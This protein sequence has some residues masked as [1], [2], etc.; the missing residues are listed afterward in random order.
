[1]TR[2]SYF[3][4]LGIMFTGCTINEPVLPKWDTSWQVHLKGDVIKISELLESNSSVSDSLDEATGEQ[5]YFINISDTSEPRQVSPQDLSTKTAD[6]SFVNKLGVFE[7]AQPQPKVSQGSTFSEIFADYNPQVGTPFPV[8]EP[9]VLTPDPRET[10][11]DEF[12][13]L[14]IESA[15]ISVVFHNDLILGIDSG[16]KIILK[17]LTRLNE[18]DSGLI[19]TIKFTAPIPPNTFLESNTISL[20]GKTISNQLQLTYRIPLS[21]TDS[22]IILTEDDLNSNFFTEVIMSPVKVNRA[23]AKIPG[24]SIIRVNTAPV[25]TDDHSIRIAEI[26]QGRISLLV[27]NEMNIS[28][29][30]EIELPNFTD[31]NGATLIASKFV[32]AQS[33]ETLNINLAG[34]ALQNENQN[35]AYVENIVYNVKVETQES[36]DHVWLSADDQVSV[37]MQMDTLFFKSMTGNIAPMEIAFDPVEN[38]NLFQLE[39]FTGSFKLPNLALTFNFHNELDFDIAMDMKVTGY[40]RDPVTKLITDSVSVNMNENLDRSNTSENLYTVVLN[41]QSSTPSIVDLVAIMPTEIIVTGKALI[42]GEGSIRTSDKVWIDYTIDSPFTIEIDEPLIYLNET[43]TIGDKDLSAEKRN[44]ISEN[45][46][47]VS[48]KILS[49]NAMPIGTDFVFYMSTDSTNLFT[50]VI[51]DSSE[52]IILASQ[53]IAASTNEEGFVDKKQAGEHVFKLNKKQIAI[54]E[55]SPLYYGVKVS[56]GATAKAIRFRP[57]DQLSFETVLDFDVIMGP[58]SF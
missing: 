55:Q 43:E 44:K 39:N 46:T 38:K 10:T 36:L 16:M 40:H 3:L 9:R 11:F 34:Y 51:T 29:D 18:P 7:V 52:K 24:Q 57:S 26:D 48:L 58:D 4:L 56:I 2:M 20:A 12:K 1:M 25:D 41:K 30:I 15:T 21:G 53:I 45:F 54:F 17:D 32:G 8:I 42:A 33:S 14:E 47:E 22:V 31:S 28:S 50:D 37:S 13:Q 49:Q 27:K 35:G 5:T 19:D 23:L 6:Q